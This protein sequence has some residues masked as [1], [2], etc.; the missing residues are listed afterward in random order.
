MDFKLI[1]PEELNFVFC[2]GIF[3]PFLN[4]MLVL[5]TTTVNDAP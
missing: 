3:V 2:F 4:C 5:E 1:N